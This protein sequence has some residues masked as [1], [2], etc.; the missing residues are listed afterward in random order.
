MDMN[1]ADLSATE[2]TGGEAM[3]ESQL[4]AIL[5]QHENNAI[6]Y[7]T[8]V[9]ASDQVNAINYYY[10]RAF[11]DEQGGRTRGRGGRGCWTRTCRPG[12]ARR[13]HWVHS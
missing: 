8:S 10:R 1:V 9:I 3:S 11:G 4:A 6:G 2:Q 7:Y 12:P 5:G 13:A